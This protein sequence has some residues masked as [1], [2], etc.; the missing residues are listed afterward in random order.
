MDHLL[1][2]IDCKSSYGSYRLQTYSNLLQDA[3]F[4]MILLEKRRR[5]Y[6]GFYY[7]TRLCIKALEQYCKKSMQTS[8]IVLKEFCDRYIKWPMI[9]TNDPLVFGEFA[10]LLLHLG[11]SHP[12]INWDSD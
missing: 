8:F 10:D 11:H 4:E 9:A 3:A 2:V 12:G 6:R 7:R 5:L 1:Q